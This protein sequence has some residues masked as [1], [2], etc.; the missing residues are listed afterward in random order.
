MKI[1]G[2]TKGK[3]LS[4]TVLMLI[5]QC[6]PLSYIVQIAVPNDISKGI[7][8]TG[9]SSRTFEKYSRSSDE[10][11]VPLSSWHTFGGGASRT[12]LPSDTLLQI[13]TPGLFSDLPGGTTSFASSLAS[14]SGNIINFSQVPVVGKEQIIYAQGNTVEIYDVESRTR[15]WRANFS[16]SIWAQ[17]AAGDIDNDGR[18]ELVVFQ[19]TGEGIILRPRIEWRNGSFILYQDQSQ[20]DMLFNY[21]LPEGRWSSPYIQDVDSDG[22]KEIITAAGSNLYILS[23]I[24]NTTKVSASLQG[25]CRSSPSSTAGYIVVSSFN[26]T[27]QEMYLE[28]FI[29]SGSSQL[30]LSRLWNR[31]YP[32]SNSV[33]SL[34][35]TYPYPSPVVQDTSV[36]MI[37]QTGTGR[38]ELSCLNITSGQQRWNK[39][40]S[41][42]LGLSTPSLVWSESSADGTIFLP[43]SSPLIGVTSQTRLLALN[44]TNGNERWYLDLPLAIN[45][46]TLSSPVILKPLSFDGG[47]GGNCCFWLCQ[48][49]AYC[50]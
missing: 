24:N 27:A 29:V 21:S 3:W 38:C 39:T 35:S 19:N 48:L 41:S 8:N 1:F 28:C 37:V 11:T 33:A 6:L 17:P 16:G 42:W 12:H 46:Y 9:Y 22:I 26:D 4:L 7:Y 18:C 45:G 43:L 5:L 40:F 25:E 2:K 14:F 36:F 44:A 34:L 49:Y 13:S 15:I 30:S 23:G 31:T 20:R 50:S 10:D 32:A 47:S